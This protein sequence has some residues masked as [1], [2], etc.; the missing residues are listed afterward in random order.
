MR[1]AVALL[2]KELRYKPKDRGLDSFAAAEW[3]WCRL[4]L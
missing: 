4:N 1:H 2:V 3:P